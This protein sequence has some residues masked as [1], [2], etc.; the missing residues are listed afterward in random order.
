MILNKNKIVNAAFALSLQHG[1]DNV[2]I[3]QIQKEA[4]VSAGTI[5]YHFK[6]KN[7]ILVCMVNKYLINCF[8][9]FKEAIRDFNGSFIE[10][11]EFLGKYKLYDF[12]KIKDRTFHNNGKLNYKTYFSLFTS[13][14]HQNPEVRHLFYELQEE[15]FNFCHEFIKRA[16]ENEEIRKDIDIK[17]MTIFIKTCLDGYIFGWKY[18]T[19]FSPGEILK[20]DIKMIWEAVKK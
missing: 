6:D 8:F 1:F 17:T 16:S 11:I 4:G 13:I 19:K 14:Y 5:Y 18:R 10:K 9:E 2:S 15:L 12:I 7:E 3:R 20:A